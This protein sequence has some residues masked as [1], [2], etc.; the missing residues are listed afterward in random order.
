MS[1][2]SGPNPAPRLSAFPRGTTD[3]PGGCGSVHA[4]GDGGR[5]RKRLVFPGRPGTGIVDTITKT[6]TVPGGPGRHSRCTARAWE[7]PGSSGAPKISSP[8]SHVSHVSR[9]SVEEL[10]LQG[11]PDPDRRG[12]AGQ[13]HIGN[14]RRSSGPCQP[15]IG[16]F[17]GR[18]CRTTMV[19]NVTTYSPTHRS[20]RF[21]RNSER[22]SVS[23]GFPVL[24]S[25]VPKLGHGS[26]GWS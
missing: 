15:T 23:E 7:P 5:V 14:H 26:G 11:C 16:P 8:A 18:A 4:V 22:G 20:G 12:A 13:G 2:R 19:P 21:S 6:R 9:G 1:G 3:A 24:Y 25:N 17:S 10:S